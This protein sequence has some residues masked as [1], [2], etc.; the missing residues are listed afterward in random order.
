MFPHSRLRHRGYNIMN[1]A[2]LINAVTE[3][4]KLT[5]ADADRAVHAVLSSITGALRGGDQVVLVG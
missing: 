2:D 3:A 4:T 1:K 5:H